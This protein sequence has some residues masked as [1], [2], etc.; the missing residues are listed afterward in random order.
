M[1]RHGSG[2]VGAYA[3][4]AAI[5]IVAAIGLGQPGVAG[6][7]APF[8]LALVAGLVNARRSPPEVS[9]TVAATPMEILE[10]ERT[11]IRISI[12]SGD[13]DGRCDVG[14]SLPPSV[15]VVEGH[16]CQGLRLRA[17]AS[18][19][20][21]LVVEARRWGAHRLGPAVLRVRDAGALFSWEG[22]AGEPGMLRVRPRRSPTRAV[23]RPANAGAASGDHTAR[24]RAEGIEFADLRPYVPGD[25]IGRVN[26]RATARRGTV[27]VNERHPDR[28]TDVVLFIDTFGERGLADT[29]RIASALADAY[30][31]RHDR[32]G[33]VTFGGV[34]SWLE[35]GSGQRQRERLDE[36]LLGAESFTSFAWKSIARVPART[37][38]PRG[39]VIAVSPLV[40]ERTRTALVSM[41]LRRMDLAVVEVPLVAGPEFRSTWSGDVAARLHA[42][43]HQ[44][45]RDRF[46]AL[47]VA[48]VQ[49][50]QAGGVE[51]A[52]REIDEYRRRA[53]VRGRR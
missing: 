18:A 32:V 31:V 3:T 2:K 50:D 37:L 12:T 15:V 11:E 22:P 25:R 41:A 36:A 48:V 14:L 35:P 23:V 29:V 6:L 16:A 5:A 42:M 44:S 38:P 51:Q 33:L 39:L 52:V 7:G 13:V 46:L 43:Q 34:L 20:V 27:M 8:A 45:V 49:W 47:G 53:R 26:W 9:V 1:T 30:L 21:L 40:D 10:G 19:E 4:L 28:N 17:G 24:T